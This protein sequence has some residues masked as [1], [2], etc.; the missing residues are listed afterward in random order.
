LLH[1]LE[2]G[3][4]SPHAAP[5]PGARARHTVIAHAPGRLTGPSQHLTQDV[6]ETT[7]ALP[8]AATAREHRE[9]HRQQRHHHT[10]HATAAAGR[11]STQPTFS[12]LLN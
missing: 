2:Q 10:S 1:L 5:H 4:K 12:A 7:T 8:R 3:T 11:S 9:H 6:A